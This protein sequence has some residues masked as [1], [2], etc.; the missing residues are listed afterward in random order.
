[1]GKLF[2]FGFVFLIFFLSHFFFSSVSALL[3]HLVINCCLVQIQCTRNHAADPN[4]PETDL[5]NNSVLYSKHLKWIPQGNQAV[6]FA[7]DPISVV[8]DDIIIAKLRPGQ[9]IEAELHIVKGIGRDHAKFS[10]VATAAYRLMPEIILTEK[11]QNE[12]ADRL[13][14]VCP[15]NVFDIEDVAGDDG[16]KVRQAYVARPRLCSMCRE[17]VRHRDVDVSNDTGIKNSSRNNSMDDED[18]E[19]DNRSNGAADQWGKKVKLRKKRDHF[20][21]SVESTGAYTAEEVFKESLK[22]FSEK[23]N[24]MKEGRNVAW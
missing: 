10:P 3:F 23:L 5:Y 15:M 24:Q 14:K 21:F 12:E 22:I 2:C 4:G 1:L 6:K 20:I 9:S 13:V 16:R 11:I 8:H 17:C 19:D 18:I 7:N